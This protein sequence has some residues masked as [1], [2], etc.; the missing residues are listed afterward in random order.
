LEGKKHPFIW[1]IRSVEIFVSVSNI[2]SWLPLFYIELCCF[3]TVENAP[4]IRL[5]NQEAHK[6]HSL[7][8][9]Q[10]PKLQAYFMDEQINTRVLVMDFVDGKTIGGLINEVSHPKPI[11]LYFH[12]ICGLCDSAQT[13][14]RIKSIPNLRSTL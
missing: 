7:T 13:S 5:F 6:L 2:I 10:I 11:S 3:R 4:S 8:H 14:R 9:P 12:I 1:R